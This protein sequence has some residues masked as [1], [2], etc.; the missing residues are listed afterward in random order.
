MKTNILIRVS[1]FFLATLFVASLLTTALRA[2]QSQFANAKVESQALNQGLASTVQQIAAGAPQPAW[3]AYEVPAIP[4]D[5]FACCNDRRNGTACGTCNLE[6]HGKST[7]ISNQNNTSSQNNTVK[8]EQPALVTVLFRVEQKQVLRIRVYSQNC[9]LDAGGLS[10]F[11][12]M[13][14]KSEDSVAY[15]TQFVAGKSLEGDGDNDL[16]Q[17]ALMA[18][19]QHADLSADRALAS[20]V[21]PDQP[22]SLRE[23]ASFWLGA[24]RGKS[25]L[26]LLEKMAASDPNSDVRAK[27]AFALFVSREPQATNDIIHMAKDDSDAHVRGQALFWL[28]Q[29]AGQKA[30][31]TI[32]GAI[33]NDPDTEV[34]KKAVFALTQMPEGEGVPKL[35]EVAQTNKNPEVRKQAVFW[36]GQSHDPR[37]LAFFEKILSQ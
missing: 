32:T 20:F 3:I 15:L 17:D 18:I 19:A 31:A 6:E 36:L 7:V 24:S 37:A 34:K 35:I 16:P 9:T 27:V 8:L 5:H 4:G 28:G 11:W 1:R 25:G 22:A 26:S 21:S 33:Q 13:G 30:A 12:L 23:K 29:K 2:D 10:V 14:V